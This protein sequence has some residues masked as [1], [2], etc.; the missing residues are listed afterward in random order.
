MENFLPAI[1]SVLAVSAISLIGAITL[2]LR[3]AMIKRYLI[4]FVSFSAGALFG[5]VFIHLLPEIIESGSWTLTTSLMII[6]GIVVSFALEK[7]IHWRHCHMPY[8]KGHVHRFAYMNLFGDALH[9]AIDG[10]IIGASF[11]V[12]IPVGIAT[13]LA[14]MLHEIPQEIGDFAVLLHGGFQKKKALLYNFY[15]ALAAIGGTIAAFLLYGA[16]PNMNSYLIPFAAGSFLYI[17]GADL[18]PELHKEESAVKG[19]FQLG[20]FL[21][22]VAIMLLLLLVE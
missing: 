16:V 5:D 9:N 19:F 10:L 8:E 17:A 12:G 13:T 15:S 22:G 7:I 1:I 18:I 20:F 14:V 2:S 3:E 4:Y 11:M 6:F 21:L